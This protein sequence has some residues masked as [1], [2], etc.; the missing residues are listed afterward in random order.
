M[1]IL[2]KIKADQLQARKDKNTVAKDLL[3]TLIGE[4]ENKSR[5]PDTKPGFEFAVIK[6]FADKVVEF[7]A[8]TSDQDVKTRLAIEKAILD[9]YTPKMVSEA[10][11]VEAIRTVVPTGKMTA[12]DRGPVMKH[13]KEQFQERLD[14]ALAMKICREQ[15]EI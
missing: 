7:E 9:Q 2:E 1:S 12:K 15:F 4:I 6:S 14:S 8:L 10:D 13:L 5:R 11:L 3:T